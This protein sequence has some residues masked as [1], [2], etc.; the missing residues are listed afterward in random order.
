VQVDLGLLKLGHSV[1][2]SQGLEVPVGVAVRIGLDGQHAGVQVALGDVDPE[3]PVHRHDVHVGVRAE[4]PA[5]AGQDAHRVAALHRVGQ[6][7][8]PSG[9]GGGELDGAHL[10]VGG[11]LALVTHPCGL[12]VEAEHTLGGQALGRAEVDGDRP[13]AQL[14]DVD[15]V[16]HQASRICRAVP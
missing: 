13:A 15:Q 11:E 3:L 16:G 6:V 4:R 7:E 9:L 2:G 14:G 1:G 5:G 10:E 12:D 8:H